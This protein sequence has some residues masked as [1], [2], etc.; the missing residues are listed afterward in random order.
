MDRLNLSNKIREFIRKYKY[1]VLVLL[2]GLML[3]LLP[4]NKT[5]SSQETA[6]APAVS[7]PLDEMLEEILSRI[8]GAGE[9]RVLLTEHTGQEIRYQT[10][11]E[12]EQ[13]SDSERQRTNTVLVEGSDSHDTGLIQRVDAPVYR[14]AVVVCQGG[15]SAVGSSGDDLPDI[16]R[17]HVTDREHARQAGGRGFVCHD[18]SGSVQFQL[19]L[20]QARIGLSAYTDEQAVSGNFF[21][22]SRKTV[23][24]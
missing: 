18:V 23:G 8:E 1:A 24:I 12:S 5:V 2:L 9:V 19:T 17:P 16:F 20:Y 4:G 13:D 10:D 11:G 22:L 6:A 7:Q 21:F 15:D 14:G 3:M